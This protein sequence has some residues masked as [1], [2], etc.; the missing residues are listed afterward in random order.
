MI[1]N[2]IGKKVLFKD[3]QVGKIIMTNPSDYFR[4][5]VQIGDQFI[6]LSSPKQSLEIEDIF[7]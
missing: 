3:R 4:P 2:F 1:P 5:L 7:I 6:D